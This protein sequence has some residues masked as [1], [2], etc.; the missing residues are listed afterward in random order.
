MRV[1]FFHR[2]CY[3][4]LGA[5]SAARVG[6]EAVRSP[7]VLRADAAA[8]KGQHAPVEAVNAVPPRGRPADEL[9]PSQIGGGGARMRERGVWCALVRRYERPRAQQRT[10]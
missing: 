3:T 4:I 10:S 5:A 8:G 1:R 9:P 7:D 2:Q 6:E